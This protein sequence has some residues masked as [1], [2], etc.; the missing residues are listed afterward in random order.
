M[1]E[2]PKEMRRSSFYISNINSPK[3]G[4]IKSINYF[5]NKSF[6]NM[7]SKENPFVNKSPINKNKIRSLK[8][9]PL[10]KSPLKMNSIGSSKINSR[11]KKNPFQTGIFGNSKI[12]PLKY[13]EFNIRKKLIDLSTQIEKNDLFNSKFD[14]FSPGRIKSPNKSS[15]NLKH[16]FLDNDNERTSYRLINKLSSKSNKSYKYIKKKSSNSVK[17]PSDKS[18][19]PSSYREKSKMEKKEKN[20]RKI[21]RTKI[22]YDSLEDN[23]TDIEKENEGIF[24]SPN[25]NF[26]LIFD[27]LIIISTLV[28]AFYNPYYI[29]TMKCFC[30]PIHF[31]IKYIYFFIDILFICDLLLGFFRAY[32]NRKFQLV[33]SVKDI[34][35]NYLSSEFLMDF[36]QSLPIFSLLIT[37]CEKKEKNICM[38]Y[39]MSNKQMLLII[40]TTFKQLKFYKM[41]NKKK[42]AFI[43]QLYEL[44]NENNTLEHILNIIIIFFSAFFGFYTF[45]SIHIFIANQNSK[46]WII[47]YN[48]QDSSIFLL[49]LNSFY[50]IITT[51]TTVGYGDMLGNSLAETIFKII[52]LTLGISLYSWIVSNIGNY[53]N[54]ESRIS[55][56]FNKDEGILEEIRISYP[57]MPYKLYNQ[58]F[59]HL[60]LRKLRQKKLD[61]NLLI[62]SLPYSL[63]NTILFTIHNQVIRNFKIFKKCQNSDFINQILT[64]F[65]PLFSRKNAILIYENQL[66]ENIIFVKEGRLSLEAAI[67]IDSPE[68]SINDYIHSKFIDINDHTAE[69][70]K[71]SLNRTK[72]IKQTDI[73]INNNLKTT[74]TEMNDSTME[75]EIGRCEFEGGEFE[76]S[77]YHFINIVSITKNE[78]FGIVYMFLAKPSPLSLRVK[79]KKAELFLLRKF[80]ALAIS[81]KFP[82]I[83][84]KQY[85]KSYIN[86]NSIKKKTI[87]QIKHYCQIMGKIF[88][89][90]DPNL[91]KK[92]N[93]TIKEIL[94]KAKQKDQIKMNK[95]DIN[96]ISNIFQDSNLKKNISITSKPNLL[97]VNNQIIISRLSSIPVKV[98]SFISKD[99]NISS[100]ETN[101]Q[102]KNSNDKSCNNIIS[103]RDDI[104]NTFNNELSNDSNNKLNN[105][106]SKFKKSRISKGKK[107]EKTSKKKLSVSNRAIKTFNCSTT[108]EQSSVSNLG[109]NSSLKNILNNIKGEKK[110]SIS[111]PNNKNYIYKL[112]K[113]IKKLKISKLYYKTLIKKISDKLKEFKKQNNK[114]FTNEIIMTLVNYKQEREKSINNDEDKNKIKNKENENK[115][116][117]N[118]NET[119][120]PKIINNLI[121]QNNNNYICSFSDFISSDSNKSSSSTE[122]KNELVIINKVS[123]LSYF[124]EYKNLKELTKGEITKNKKFRNQSLN[125]IKDLYIKL[126]KRAP[127]KSK[128]S[129]TVFN[130]NNL[131]KG[132]SLKEH[133]AFKSDKIFSLSSMLSEDKQNLK[134]KNIKKNKNNNNSN[135]NKS[136]KLNT[137]LN[138]E[139]I[140]LRKEIINESDWDKKSSKNISK[141]RDRLKFSDDIIK[142]KDYISEDNSSI[143]KKFKSDKRVRKREEI[144]N[145]K[146][147]LSREK[148]NK[149]KEVTHNEFCSIF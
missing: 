148:E 6:N 101:T 9:N 134:T 35:T 31:I 36:F 60:E 45:I 78:S 5:F 129:Q 116:Q 87:K 80:D 51:I 34:I 17:K 73:D 90:E 38:N 135:M 3:S 54:N 81:K 141:T 110:K 146:N 140:N 109:K 18:I 11:M 123:E 84:R 1:L 24:L 63:R 76:E 40:F 122:R 14:I 100:E 91:V 58:I 131:L 102:L 49:F 105:L 57:N 32:Y 130:T 127:K 89:E 64:N 112:K 66:I 7:H 12:I 77:N 136:K 61:V 118:N 53:V 121:V 67:D 74:Y 133:K 41:T 126:K 93:Y 98:K 44:T 33:T 28:V 13:M 120:N 25:S 95:S 92:N 108:N 59:H 79:S 111:S 39:N 104:T 117:I 125:Y 62:N 37:R 56:R 72:S 149:S 65:I 30:Y 96:S 8:L 124:A 69:A 71:D 23:E 82:N 50:F 85:N 2:N 20:Y 97:N 88:E 106:S 47:S 139:K 75:R 22:L 132:K 42:N 138:L 10:K 48:L 68:K 128:K 26:I 27:I 83:W 29:S 43:F 15:K 115:T 94:E 16:F 114:S 21:I 46:S 99:K 144:I 4:I 113:K 137:T 119:N 86:M 70:K 55:I 143:E 142:E 107:L 147:E 52:L 145:I 103:F 19:P